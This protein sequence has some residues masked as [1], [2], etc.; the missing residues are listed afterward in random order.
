MTSNFPALV[1]TLALFI[2]ALQMSLC[3]AVCSGTSTMQ[4]FANLTFANAVDFRIDGPNCYNGRIA[5]IW[6][7]SPPPGN[8]SFTILFS[9]R[10]NITWYS[11]SLSGSYSVGA[12]RFCTLQPKLRVFG[13]W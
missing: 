3:G 10:E 11:S 4:N 13:F 1:V 6:T 2:F 5:V 8:E 12:H 7:I 9:L